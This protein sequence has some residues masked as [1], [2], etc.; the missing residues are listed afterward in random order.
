MPTLPT[1]LSGRRLTPDHAYSVIVSDISGKPIE[2]AKAAS[3]V[4]LIEIRANGWL[5]QKVAKLGHR[6]A[7]P[8][9]VRKAKGIENPGGAHARKTDFGHAVR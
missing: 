8:M 4:E 5:L 6:D 2:L 9:I 3:G 1:H 7:S